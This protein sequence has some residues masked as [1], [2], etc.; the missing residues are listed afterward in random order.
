M[1]TGHADTPSGALSVASDEILAERA[2]DGDD[3]AFEALIHRHGP[4]IRAYVTR[5]VGSVTEADDVVQEA[6]Y[7]AW[8][9]LPQLRDRKAVKA[10][11]I[12]IA[13]RQAFTHLRRKPTDMA[14][15]NLET[16]L[17]AATQPE[18]V[19]V[20]NAQLKALSDALNTL[21]DDQRW[22]WLLREVADLS[23]D[24]IAEQL[25][26]PTSTVRGKLARAR[27]SIYAQMEEWR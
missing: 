15:Q 20:R 8:R 9:Q 26:I 14:L 19:A 5:I 24:D 16:A 10:W 27:V 4:L 3:A 18:N 21:P 7:L 17:P 23:Y 12:R 6:L 22:C 1:T 2:V 11:L 25:Q 13:G